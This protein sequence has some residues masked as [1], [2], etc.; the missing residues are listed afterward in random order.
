MQLCTLTVHL[1]GVVG[2]NG[3]QDA[4]VARYRNGQK[5]LFCTNSGLPRDRQEYQPLYECETMKVP[6]DAG[7]STYSS[8]SL[9]R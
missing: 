9:L 5:Q 3:R 7:A 2:L 6:G 8:I 4:A 1:A